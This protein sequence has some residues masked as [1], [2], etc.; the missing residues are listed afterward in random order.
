MNLL[1][2]PSLGSVQAALG[3]PA[4][5]ALHTSARVNELL[6]AGVE[7]MAVGADLHAKL[8]AGRASQEFVAARAVHARNRVVRVDALLHKHHSSG[9]LRAAC[10]VRWPQPAPCERLR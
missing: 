7:R 3:H 4:L 9:R 8:I 2:G 1:R 5:E 6:P 10:A